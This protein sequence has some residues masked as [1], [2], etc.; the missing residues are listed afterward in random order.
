M[1]WIL[2][3]FSHF[4]LTETKTAICKS[5]LDLVFFL[6]RVWKNFCKLKKK[7]RHVLVLK[8]ILDYSVLDK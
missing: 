6:V 8:I 4:Q 7:I 3:F 2:K 1:N 5:F